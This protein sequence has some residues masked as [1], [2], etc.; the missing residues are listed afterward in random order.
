MRKHVDYADR[1]IISISQDVDNVILK[2]EWNEFYIFIELNRYILQ[3]IKSL[4][5]MN[6]GKKVYFNYVYKYFKEIYINS[7]IYNF[8]LMEILY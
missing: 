6:L 7:F 3:L 2:F 1:R 8:S 4:D 5:L